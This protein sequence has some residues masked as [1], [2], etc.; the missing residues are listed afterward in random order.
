VSG[1]ALRRYVPDIG[2]TAAALIA[3]AALSRLLGGGL[4][5][6]ATGPILAAAAVGAVLPAVLAARRVPTPVRMLVGTLAVVIVSVWASDPRSTTYGFPTPH[7]WHLLARHLQAAHSI[8]VA[9]S[10]PLHPAQGIV[11]LAALAVG[12]VSVLAAVILHASDGK[13]HLYPGGA[14]LCLF[15]LLTF[16]CAENATASAALPLS[17]FVAVCAITLSTAR[18][19]AAG[20]PAVSA[21]QAWKS[22]GTVLSVVLIIGVSLI[23]FTVTAAPAARIVSVPVPPTAL[24]LTSRLVA[25]EVHDANVV[26]FRAHSPYPTYW[27]VAVLD[28]L[29]QGVWVAGPDDVEPA[30]PNNGA[31]FVSTVDVVHFSSRVVPAPPATVAVAGLGAAAITQEGVQVAR[32]TTNRE[33]YTTTSVIPVSDPASLVG[34]GGA[35]YPPGLLA[36]DLSLPALPSSIHRLAQEATIGT[37]TPLGQAEALVDWFRSGRFRYTLDPPAALPGVN[38]LVSFL[39]RTRAG[40]CE[41]FAGAFTVLARSLGLPTRLV[42]GFTAGTYSGPHEVTVKGDDAHAWP[43]VY[44][45]AAAGWV[46]FEPTPQRLTGEVTPDGVVGPTGIT[47]APPPVGAAPPTTLPSQPVTVPTTIPPTTVPTSV[48]AVAPVPV[49][50]HGGP[51]SRFPWWLS[52][53]LGSLVVAV[54]MAAAAMRSRLRHLDTAPPVTMSLRAAATVDRALKRAGVARPPWQTLTTLVGTL[55]ERI[56]RFGPDVL[57]GLPVPDD[58]L[59]S[60]V[61][62]AILVAVTADRALYEPGPLDAATAARARRAAQRVQRALR[63]HHLRRMVSAAGRAPEP[64]ATSSP[65]ARN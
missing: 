43:E 28:V 32:R 15:A 4:G 23:A 19:P 2:L 52:V 12:L 21:L 62:D 20:G 22:A 40:T 13:G 48:P 29:R 31:T 39:T 5:G 10:F 33:R 56:H 54:L 45:G 17:S 9:F 51:Q 59:R 24:S 58:Q 64:I 37:R 57:G 6:P 16:A 47:T 30:P 7:A 3:A 1:A 34:S 41:Q 14:L 25:L 50:H 65:T 53:V 63:Q 35:S 42:V 26:L 55:D 8:L 38:P 36:A 49:V 46:S 27:Q 44:L 18:R 11:F 61:D 60:L